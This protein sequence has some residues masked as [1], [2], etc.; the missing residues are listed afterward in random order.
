[1]GGAW[2]PLPGK[3]LAAHRRQAQQPMVGEL[4]APPVEMLVPH[5]RRILAKAVEELRRLRHQ[6]TRG[7]W[8]GAQ[9][10][11]PGAMLVAHRRQAWALSGGAGIQ[12]LHRRRKWGLSGDQGTSG[13]NSSRGPG[14]MHPGA[15]TAVA[16]SM[17]LSSLAEALVHPR[18]A[19][20][21]PVPPALQ[22]RGS[23]TRT[24][25]SVVPLVSWTGEGGTQTGRGRW[26]GGRRRGGMRTLRAPQ[27]GAPW[28]LPRSQSF[29][30]KPHGRRLCA[31]ALYP[32]PH[33]R[34]RQRMGLRNAAVGGRQRAPPHQRGVGRAPRQ[35]MLLQGH[36]LQ[37]R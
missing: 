4:G 15:A 10:A 13:Q 26:G 5:N 34:R 3:V 19:W 27:A 22:R 14:W 1:M 30:T 36:L 37:H 2:C 8:G 17:V 21:R 11:P 6:Q 24:R 29:G 31:V 16:A 20:V 12:V 33:A 35:H 18:R 23:L 7:G 9:G 28:I 32:L 25:V